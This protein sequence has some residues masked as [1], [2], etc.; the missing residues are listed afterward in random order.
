MD[1]DIE[2]AEA[3]AEGEHLVGSEMERR[4]DPNLVTGRARYTDDISVPGMTHL[5]FARSPYGHADVTSIDTSAAESM[6]GVVAVFTWEDVEAS[7]SPGRIR[8]EDMIPMSAEVPDHPVLADGHVHYHGQPVVAV[9]AES[10]YVAADAVDAVNVEY[11]RLDAVVNPREA[12]GEGAPTIFES[13]P[14]NIISSGELGDE[15]ATDEAFETADNVVELD[16]VNNRLI[17]NAMETRGAI[18]RMDDGRLFVEMTSQAPHR[19]RSNFAKTLGMRET[20]IRVNSPDVGGGFGEKSHHFPGDAMA[21]WAAVQLDSPVKWVATRSENYLEGTHGRDHVTTAALAFDDD[22]TMRGLRADTYAAVG[23]YVLDIAPALALMYG[24]LLAG[25]YDL[26]AIFC[27]SRAVFTNTAPISS[28]R[29]AGRP[30]AIYVIERLVK[31]AADSIDMS[32]AEFRRRNL[33]DPDDFPH[34][35]AVGA[36]YDSGDYEPTMDRALELVDYEAVRE[37][38]ERE[39][40][41]LVGVGLACFVESTGGGFESGVVRVHPDGGA[42][43]FAGTHSHGQGH[44]TTYAQIV[45]DELGV[46]YDDVEVVE[47]D[48][49]RIPTGTGTFGSRS[50][51]TGGSS[52]A[53]SARDVV[54]QARQVAASQFEA[55]PEDVA[56][57][58]GTFHVEGAPERSASF[59]GVAKAAYGMMLPPGVEPGLEATTFFEPDGTAY[60]FGTHAVVVAVDPDSGDIEIERYAAVDDCGVQINPKIVEGQIHGAVAQGVGQALYEGA[61][62]DDNGTLVTG[63]LQDY[64]VPTAEQVPEMMT[65]STVT[66]SP[67][68]PLGVKGVGESGTLA[69]PPAVV[70]AVIDALR[71]LGV[72]HVDMPLTGET[73]WRAVQD[74]QATDD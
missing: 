25:E 3:L 47:G 71:P 22:G 35:T 68:N 10:R 48:T 67:T 37:R 43:V 7:D 17:P 15:D 30:E 1:S 20:D 74:A 53:Q 62:Y 33:I 36:T 44:E 51:I 42:T 40:G 56:Y 8:V 60:S 28:Y 72:D 66:P 50:T 6:D 73:V 45:A 52:V 63:S 31:R 39:D 26:P 27:R 12:A 65:D 41:R 34:E 29:G 70:N 24:R 59:E 57:E 21:A 13:C 11:E 19:H 61:E 46:D 18:A 32:P 38:T 5:M 23:G 54:E 58:D 55:A 9:V 69:A 16:L 14:D 49:D 2:S 64:A 4:E